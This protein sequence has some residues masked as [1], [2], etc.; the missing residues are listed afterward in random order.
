LA[1]DRIIVLLTLKPGRDA[2]DYEQW[3]AMTDLPT[4]RGLGSVADFRVYQATGLFGRGGKAP[5]DYIEIL[6]IGTPERLNGDLAS[7]TM[8]RVAGEFADWADAVFI[9]T[10]EIAGQPGDVEGGVQATP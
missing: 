5:Y 3:A 9:T 8:Q 7:P 1:G 2:A 10:R 4:V 6:D